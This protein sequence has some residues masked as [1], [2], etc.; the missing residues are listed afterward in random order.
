M[1]MKLKGSG[2]INYSVDT[3]AELEALAGEEGEVVVV[4]DENRGG[5]FVYRSAESGTNNSGTIFNGW[6]RQYYGAVNVKWFGANNTRTD[7]EVPIQSALDSS[8]NVEVPLD[9]ICQMSGQ[10]IINT[11]LTRLS[12]SGELRWLSGIDNLSAIQVNADYVV[13]DGIYCTNPNEL[14]SSGAGNRNYGIEI[15]ADN[16][17]VTNSFIHTFETGIAVRASGEF[18]NCRIT[19]NYVLDIIGAGDGPDDVT[20]ILGEDR[21]DGIVSWGARTIITGNHVSCKEGKDARIGI[22]CEGLPGFEVDGGDYSSSMSI[23]SNNS[24]WGTFRRSIVLERMSNSIISENTVKDSTWFNIGVIFCDRCSVTSNTIVY[25]RTSADLTGSAWSPSYS[26]IYVYGSSDTMVNLNAISLEDGCSISNVLYLFSNA[27]EVSARNIFSSNT[28]TYSGTVTV[29]NHFRNSG[30]S[31]DTNVTNNIFN[32]S[33]TYGINALD[34]ER[35][36]ISN[37]NISTTTNYA[38]RVESITEK[39]YVIQGNSCK[40]SG[41]YCIYAV[42]LVGANVSDNFLD[43]STNGININGSTYSVVKDNIADITGSIVTFSS[44]TGNIVSDN[45]TIV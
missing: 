1:S 30:T 22:H 12:K 3:I 14:N 24:V 35:G 43:I 8:I 37:N 32:S 31:Y 42:N 15:L 28:L 21:G 29:L 39:G 16:V 40:S 38:I 26:A 45:V 6:C 13:I 36:N 23:I 19:D 4:S 5:T 11:P 10:V 41:S 18:Y 34:M 7:N 27:T 9:L 44:G 17:T 2:G 33:A 20:S 25:T